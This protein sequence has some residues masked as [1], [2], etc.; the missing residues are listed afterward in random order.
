MLDMGNVDSL[1]G[2]YAVRRGRGRQ[3]VQL[4]SAD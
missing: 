2:I 3:M 1:P 4:R